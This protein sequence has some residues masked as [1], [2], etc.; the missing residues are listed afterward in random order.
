M[1]RERGG[2]HLVTVFVAVVAL[3]FGQDRAQAQWGMGG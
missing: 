2:E 1:S 3:G